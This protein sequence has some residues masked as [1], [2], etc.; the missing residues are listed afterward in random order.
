M[1]ASRVI[2]ALIASCIVACSNAILAPAA[3]S[4]APTF[5][6]A[7]PLAGVPDRGDD[8]AVVAIDAGG[9]A[10]CSGTLIAPD[11]VLTSR[12]CVSVTSLASPCPDGGAAVVAALAPESLH[13]LVGDAAAA[14]DE[15]ARGRQIVVVDDTDACAED[16]AVL[17]LDTPIDDI[18]PLGVRPTGAAQGDALRTVAYA[19]S[20]GGAA[21]IKLV[22]DNALVTSVSPASLA[23]AEACA[24]GAGGPAI[25][26][27]SVEVV[28]VASL[29]GTLGCGAGAVE[30]YA[31]ADV[32][33]PFV[34]AT[35]A[36][37]ALPAAPSTGQEKTK[38]GDI[39]VGAACAR[40]EDCAAGVCA[41][42]GERRYCSRTCDAHDR[43]PTHFRCRQSAEGPSICTG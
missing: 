12:R 16:V 25:D 31:R 26:D 5:L 21:P 20:A 38:K 8:P 10:V 14:S 34:N 4:S 24:K 23:V 11:A 28:G 40:G 2:R 37:Y 9:P 30:R 3:S 7:A 6:R 33:L 17:L 39:D 1:I 27:A 42:D 36:R 35:L 19:A 32:V 41:V 43:C 18:Q 29:P 22:G 15:R 13:V